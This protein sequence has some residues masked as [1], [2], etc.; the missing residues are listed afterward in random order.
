MASLSVNSEI[1]SEKYNHDFRTSIQ[2]L[3]L[4]YLIL[5]LIYALPHNNCLVISNLAL[6]VN[7][8]SE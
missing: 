6:K 2:K 1:N 7:N 5:S 3:L 4:I 8:R